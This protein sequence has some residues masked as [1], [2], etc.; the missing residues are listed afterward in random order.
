MR[1]RDF[2]VALGGTA[3][4]P[5]AARSQERVRRAEEEDAAAREEAA[6]RELEGQ[7]GAEARGGRRRRVARGGRREPPPVRTATRVRPQW[8]A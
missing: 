5:L 3:A 6:P 8:W 2:I 4:I 7:R 1:R